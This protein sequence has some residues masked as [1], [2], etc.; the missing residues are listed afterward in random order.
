MHWL[1]RP[2]IFKK[3]NSD[4]KINHSRPH[5]SNLSFNFRFPNIKS[6]SQQKL[7]K[8]SLILQYSFTQKTSLILQI[9]TRDIAKKYTPAA[10]RKTHSLC[11]FSSRHVSG[12]CQKKHWHWTISRNRRFVFSK[13]WESNCLYIPVFLLKRLLSE[14][15]EAFIWWKLN[16]IFK[17]AHCL[18]LVR[19]FKFFHFNWNF[20]K[21]S[22]ISVFP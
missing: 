3:R 15:L 12:W 5:I 20:W 6:Q 22:Y 17:A 11:K 16:I 14:T 8:R 19:C 13:H 7:A 9:S 2:K 4:Q 1:K 10:L 18:Y 21:S